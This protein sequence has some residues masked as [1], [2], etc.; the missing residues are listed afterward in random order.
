VLLMVVDVAS[1]MSDLI[2]KGMSRIHRIAFHRIRFQ[3][4]T[5]KGEDIFRLHRYRGAQGLP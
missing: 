5:A 4:V 2:A 1:R 3:I